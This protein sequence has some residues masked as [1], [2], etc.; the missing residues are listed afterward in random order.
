MC[1]A[2]SGTCQSQLLLGFSTDQATF[3]ER[4]VCRHVH[5]N[6]YSLLAVSTRL[7]SRG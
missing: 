6:E 5:M 2:T 4:R 7:A 1:A 3:L